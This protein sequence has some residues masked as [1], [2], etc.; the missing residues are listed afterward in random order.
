[1][2]VL[3]CARVSSDVATPMGVSSDTARAD[4]P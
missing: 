3:R 2:C 1:L 4:S